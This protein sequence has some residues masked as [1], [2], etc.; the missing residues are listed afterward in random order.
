MAIVIYTYSNPYRLHRETY[1]PAIKN[2]FH[3]TASQTLANGLCDQ[4]KNDFFKGKLT[5]ITRFINHLYND[6][7]SSATEI[8]QR[9]AIDNLI[10]YMTFDEMVDGDID[11]DDIRLSLKRN[12]GYVVKSVRIMFELGMSPDHIQDAAL[13]YEQKCVVEIYRELLH[14]KNK[15]FI[16]REGFT[17]EEINAAI[18][19]TMD[20][21]WHDDALRKESDRDRLSKVK[22]DVIIVHG[23]HQFSP[24]ML[25]TIEL[26][27]EHKNVFMLFNYVPDHK[28]VYQTWLN[29]YSWFESKINISSQNFYDQSKDFAGGRIADNISAM[30]AGSTATIDYSEKVKVVQ[31]DN[32]TEFAG[33]IAK[34]FEAAE[35]ERAKDNYSHSA[36]YYMD[37]QIYSANSNVNDIL[38]IY[39]PEQFGER[40]FLDYPIGH[41]FIS[42]TNLWDEESKGMQIKN[43][44]DIYE[45]LSCGII[46]E[47]NKGQVI[48]TFDKCKLYFQDEK[49]I[50]K[51][52]KKLKRLKDRI[53][54]IDSD[55]A[56]SE[57]LSRI[58]Y[59]DVCPEEISDLIIALNALNE[60]AETFFSVFSDQ[61]NDFKSFYEKV[62]DVLVKQVLFKED[63]DLEFREIVQRVLAH[64]EE[65]KGVEAKAS[66][67]CL[68]ETMQLYLQQ[69]PKEGKGAHWIVRNFEQ[70]DGDVLRKN[71]KGQEKTYHFACLSDQDMSITHRDEFPWPLD[72]D[73]F[74]VAQ[75]PVDW[76]YQVF[77]TSRL[78]YKNFRRY[79]LVYGLAFSK[80]QIKLSY[81]KNASDNE[82]ELYYLLKVLNATPVPYKPDAPNAISKNA[83]YITIQ[84][85]L[86]RE[87]SQYDLMKYRLCQYR[88][89][90]DAVIERKTVY[91]DDF[92]LKLYLPV[93]LEHRTR[94]EFSGKTYVKSMVRNY[95]VE[96]MEE[97]S[98]DF[99]F[100]N[101]SDRVDAI[102]RAEN[103]IE[104]SAVFHGKF[105]SIKAKEMDY[106]IKRE[107][108]LT[109]PNSK[110][111]DE[112]LMDVFKNSTQ[113]EVDDVLSEENLDKDKYRKSHN[114]LCEMCADKD[115]CLEVFKSIKT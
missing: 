43:I 31:F 20:D 29:V 3:L 83:S 110:T 10:E 109:I 33:Y 23:I 80:C 100:I 64:L 35:V 69:V 108:F 75:A 51:I 94:K 77:V 74:E 106:M 45:C 38:K 98:S 40:N 57:E 65:V 22:K 55:P 26:L 14:S 5:T 11:I 8:N 58:E 12:R 41:F 48:T 101:Q 90:L 111:A 88:F 7:E 91:K 21:A 112:T 104:S 105:T 82:N 87:F 9:A 73:F 63:I 96:Q 49:T 85:P 103:Y 79:A 2:G 53:E 66:F 6:W 78:E 39:F 70:V 47:K 25:K 28:N 60:V 54:D 61:R 18:T 17:D 89:L 67:D 30:I 4:Y 84:D 19:T 62:S 24:I 72:I 86:Y 16:L 68:R 27:G 56:E 32:Q 93:L 99:P 92:L 37:E 44:Q 34:L 52:I 71:V 59:Y 115:I 81:I 36:L 42:I 102:N 113:G 15:N 13:T 107:N 46:T 76:K 50:K 97:L 95:L 114:L 1:W